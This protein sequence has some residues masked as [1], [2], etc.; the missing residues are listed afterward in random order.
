MSH[1]T[2]H[3]QTSSTAAYGVGPGTLAFP[4]PLVGVETSRASAHTR[5][6]RARRPEHTV[7]YRALAHHFERFL[8]VYEERFQATHGYLRRCVEPA[9][10][11]C[12]DCGVFDQG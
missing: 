9:A 3:P 12:L 7:L 11:P 6:Y 5:V 8:L 10:L 1:Y 2:T 4:S